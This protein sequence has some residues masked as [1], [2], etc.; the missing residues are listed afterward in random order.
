[1]T[2]STPSTPLLKRYRGTLKRYYSSGPLLKGEPTEPLRLGGGLGVSSAL[3]DAP[4]VTLS[5]RKRIALLDG[6]DTLLTAKARLD[7]DPRAGCAARRAGLRVSRRLLNFTQRQDLEVAAGVDV[8][9]PVESRGGGAGAA[10]RRGSKPTAVSG[11]RA[12]GRAGTAGACAAAAV[13]GF[14]CVGPSCGPSAPDSSLGMSNRPPLLSLSPLLSSS[15]PLLRRPHTC[16]S[17]RTTG[18]ST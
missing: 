1:V 11:G 13:C 2:P 9:W 7:Y 8:D 16:Q 10:A 5:A 15:P 4:F 14:A 12:G 6:P 17:G 3:G 18:G